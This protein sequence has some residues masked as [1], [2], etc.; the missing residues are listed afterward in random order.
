MSSVIDTFFIEKDIYVVPQ[1]RTFYYWADILDN[2]TLEDKQV[3][4]KT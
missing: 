4:T 1:K 3:T 2:G